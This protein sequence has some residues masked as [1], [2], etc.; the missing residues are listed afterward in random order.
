[1]RSHEITLGFSYP[2]GKIQ[3][4]NKLTSNL[5]TPQRSN[6]PGPFLLPLVSK[7]ELILFI[8]YMLFRKFNIIFLCLLLS[9]GEQ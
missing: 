9:L 1:M 8:F 4:S 7:P 3:G 5:F 6:Y 2:I